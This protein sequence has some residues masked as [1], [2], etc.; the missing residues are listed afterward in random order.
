MYDHHSKMLLVRRRKNVKKMV[1]CTQ[2]FFKTQHCTEWS[3]HAKP[4]ICG[5]S[6]AENGSQSQHDALY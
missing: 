6:V 1:K 3:T 2:S 4:A 5:L